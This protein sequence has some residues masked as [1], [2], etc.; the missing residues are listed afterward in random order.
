[1]TTTHNAV[2]AVMVTDR[3][4]ATRCTQYQETDRG[5]PNTT[6][7]NQAARF[8]HRRTAQP[9][10]SRRLPLPPMPW[11]AALSWCCSPVRRRIRGTCPR[12]VVG[13]DVVPAGAATRSD[14]MISSRTRPQTTM[15]LPGNVMTDEQQRHGR[16]FATRGGASIVRCATRNRHLSPARCPESSGSPSQSAPSRATSAHRLRAVNP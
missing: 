10:P 16:S 3:L 9:V 14:Q 7:R 13:P 4:T 8:L 5:Q 1:M 6:S 15:G 11:Q 2:I 12:P